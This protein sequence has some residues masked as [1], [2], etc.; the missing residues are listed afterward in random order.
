MTNATDDKH[1]IQSIFDHILARRIPICR[2]QLGEEPEISTL[3]AEMEDYEVASNLLKAIDASPEAS[4]QDVLITMR[5]FIASSE[6]LKPRSLSYVHEAIRSLPSSVSPEAQDIINEAIQEI[7]KAGPKPASVSALDS[8][9]SIKTSDLQTFIR[10]EQHVARLHEATEISKSYSE[11]E[12]ARNVIATHYKELGELHTLIGKVFESHQAP[13]V[14]VNDFQPLTKTD[15]TSA[16]NRAVQMVKHLHIYQEVEETR[17]RRTSF[18]RVPATGP[19]DVTARN[20][21]HHTELYFKT[22]RGTANKLLCENVHDLQMALRTAKN[23][24]INKIHNDNEIPGTVRA[25]SIGAI[26][27]NYE[28]CID[29][30]HEADK[31]LTQVIKIPAKKFSAQA[32]SMSM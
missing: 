12:S 9:G 28:E 27:A 29:F 32:P 17:F 26:I 5:H 18:Y 7:A 22:V 6:E 13:T 15:V 21:M 11:L 31:K 19:D 1:K 10:S 24:A 25:M 3:T 30:L 2:I 20:A 16:I 8:L 4:L 23:M 14:T